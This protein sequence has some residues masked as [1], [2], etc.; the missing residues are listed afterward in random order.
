[1]LKRKTVYIIEGLPSQSIAGFPTIL[2]I[3]N[4]LLLSIKWHLN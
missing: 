2:L 4:Q 3:T 1:M